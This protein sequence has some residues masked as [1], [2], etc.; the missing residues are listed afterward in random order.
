LNV[1]LVLRIRVQRDMVGIN[2][3]L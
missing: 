2:N 1:K 3:N